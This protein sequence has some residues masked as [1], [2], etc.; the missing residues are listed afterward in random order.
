MV[1]GP[2]VPGRDREAEREKVYSE[3]MKII[4][5]MVSLDYTIN[6]DAVRSAVNIAHNVWIETKNVVA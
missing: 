6:E 2:P 4:I 1:K 3:A 5:A